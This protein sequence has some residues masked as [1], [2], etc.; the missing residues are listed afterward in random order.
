MREQYPNLRVYSF[1]EDLGLPVIQTMMKLY[2]VP[3][4]V[5]ALVINGKAYSGFQSI[6]AIEKSLPELKKVQPTKAQF[7]VRTN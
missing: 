6:E 3:D 1:D 4:A 7:P 5:P 2:K